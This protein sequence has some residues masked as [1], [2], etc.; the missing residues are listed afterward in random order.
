MKPIIFKK[1]LF[2]F[3]FVVP[4]FFFSCSKTDNQSKLSKI[5]GEYSSPSGIIIFQSS[6]ETFA[7]D[8]LSIT[9][10]QLTFKGADAPNCI[11]N[12]IDSDNSGY[13]F[14]LRFSRTFI[15]ITDP[16]Q[17]LI[18]MSN[19]NETYL[20]LDHLFY[21]NKT[22]SGDLSLTVIFNNTIQTCVFDKM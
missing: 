7:V 17:G 15:I 20:N 13:S 12:L 10:D 19:S 22:E 2:T 3:I 14:K 5:S 16:V 18:N 8:K 6:T 21:L 4:L 9:E 1:N 11:F